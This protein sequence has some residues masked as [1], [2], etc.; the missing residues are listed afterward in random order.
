MYAS[1]LESCGFLPRPE[2][3]SFQES[4]MNIISVNVGMPREIT[5]KGISVTTGIFK[6]PVK[7]SVSMDELNLFGDRQADLTVHGGVDKAVYAYP[8]EHYEYWTQE[9]PNMELSWGVFGENLTVRGLSENTLCIGDCLRMGSAVLMVTQPRLPCYKL[10][11]RFER[12][13]MAKRFLASRRSGFYLSVVEPGEVSAAS[14]IEIVS[15]DPNKVTVADISRLYLG[16][17]RD[18]RLLE[19]ASN[20]AA[21]PE[22]WKVDLLSKVQTNYGVVSS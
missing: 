20:V 19:R 18:P 12:D 16:Q 3:T 13:D 21:L 17:T 14:T 15:H 11:I 7:G 10:G 22:A 6:E 5:W 8:A 1:R 4:R 9:L 2:D